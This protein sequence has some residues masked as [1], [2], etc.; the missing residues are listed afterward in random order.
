MKNNENKSKKS[1]FSKILDW[2]TKNPWPVFFIVVATIL[3]FILTN[4]FLD[5]WDWTA[6]GALATGVLALGIMVTVIQLGDNRWKTFQQGQ[7]SK[8]S[9]SAQFALGL[10]N[11]LR[12]P[13]S[14]K[15]L[16]DIYR[17]TPESF[18]EEQFIEL[19][20]ASTADDI[21]S[22]LDILGMIGSLIHHKILDEELVIETFGGVTVLKVWHQLGGYIR[23]QQQER[24]LQ[25]GSYLE[26]FASRALEYFRN[27]YEPG[28]INIYHREKDPSF[29]LVERLNREDIR[30]RRLEGQNV[31]RET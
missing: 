27:K 9:R 5:W 18:T 14:R 25:S 30:P 23:N 10:Y 11:E 24:G 19:K 20:F 31:L 17:E 8:K 26:D 6:I 1:N 3:F 15:V 7:E 13:K 16:Q 2:I 12:N 4:K 22:V 29:D 28:Y 21:D